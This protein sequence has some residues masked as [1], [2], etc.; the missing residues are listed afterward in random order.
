MLDSCSTARPFLYPVASEA[1]LHGLVALALLLAYL[2][3][4]KPLL[5]EADDLPRRL[6]VGESSY[7]LALG[8]R[9]RKSVLGPLS[10]QVEL[11]LRHRP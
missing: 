11:Q 3:D 10:D 2:P 9:P 6:G 4:G 8:P 5:L 1:L 7:P